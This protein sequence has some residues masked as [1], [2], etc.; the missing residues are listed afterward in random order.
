MLNKEKMVSF[1][2]TR[3]P[4]HARK[5]YA[6]ILGLTLIA[7]DPFAIVFNANGTMLRIQKVEDFKSQPFTAIGWE[8]S[9]IETVVDGLTKQKV[10]FERY[11]GMDQDQRGI[12]QSPSGA[13][14]AWF[15]D[16]DG[17]TL[18]LTEN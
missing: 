16:P 15:K 7:D 12:W 9:D 13:R 3:D 2:A 10:K 6:E 5:F 8:V 11:G 18:S 4:A 1:I 14:V 17:N